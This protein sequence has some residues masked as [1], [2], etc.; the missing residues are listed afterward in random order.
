MIIARYFDTFIIFSVVGWIY[1]CLYC[2]LKGGHWEN[3][4]FLFGPVCPIYGSAVVIAQIVFRLLPE[5]PSHSDYPIWA[6]FAICF[7]GSAIIEYSTSWVLEKIFHAV[8]WDYSDMPLNIHGRICFP[9][10]C[11]FGAAGVVV[12]RFIFP[13]IEKAA[14][15]THPL[16]NE[17]MML[18]FSMILG[19]DLALTVASL[20]KI[21]ER[22]NAAEEVFNSKI[23]S[24]YQAVNARVES[25][26]QAVNNRVGNGAQ[27]VQDAAKD[28]M[29]GLTNRE[30]YHLRS[31]RGYRPV[32]RATEV[33]EH[34]KNLFRAV[35]QKAIRRKENES[36]ED[37]IH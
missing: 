21:L 8:W 2:T 1:E 37:H 14:A 29:E 25:G 10:S 34:A 4:G 28:V 15:L 11:G 17:G 20:T 7:V 24:G 18:V 22:M 31:M 5:L 6:I 35:Q 12:V 9:A 26:Y 30:R 13:L 33:K 19:M 36:T 32:R 16:L 23:E 3:R 27:M